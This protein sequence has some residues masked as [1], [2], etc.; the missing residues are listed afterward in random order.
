MSSPV[1]GGP[2]LD[3]LFST[4]ASLPLG[5]YSGEVTD[6]N[7]TDSAGATF[8]IRGLNAKGLPGTKL[9]ILN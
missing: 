3:I 5:I 7:L 1:F 6:Q 4:S 9:N 8:M 2:N